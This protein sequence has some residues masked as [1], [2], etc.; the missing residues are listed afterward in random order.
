MLKLGYVRVTK[1]IGL[2]LFINGNYALLSGNITLNNI[3]IVFGSVA[4]SIY[5]DRKEKK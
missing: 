5:A 4:L 3:Y 1:N 2:G